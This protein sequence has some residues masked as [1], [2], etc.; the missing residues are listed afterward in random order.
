MATISLLLYIL[1]ANAIKNPA[2]D[3]RGAYSAAFTDVSGLRTGADVRTRGVQIG[4][5]TDVALSRTDDG[6]AV[7]NVTF[8]LVPPYRLTT[9][10]TLAI[11]YQ[12]LTG[13]RYIDLVTPAQ[14]GAPTNHLSTRMTTPSF[15]ITELFNGLQPVL[16]DFTT[17]ELNRF[18]QNALSV[19]EGDG[20]GLA[21]LLDSV[22]K[23]SDYTTDR[24]RVVSVLVDNLSRLADTLG[25]R[26]PE[27]I[28]FMRDVKL[29]IDA[30]MTVLDQF[31]QTAYYGPRFLEPV[32]RLLRELGLEPGLDIDKML[33]DAFSSSGLIAEAL[34]LLPNT[35]DTLQDPRLRTP[36]RGTMTC[37][38]GQARLPSKV[39]VLLNGSRVVICAPQ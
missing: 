14:P 35:L 5:V 20:S 9:T 19:V 18:M 25:G 4:K 21:P 36:V 27:L 26:S 11:K 13:I 39:D 3:A 33:A 23:L 15:D 2:P 37:P 8:S 34:R 12:N 16:K 1:I 31:G 10:T 22:Q 30:A 17:D 24:Q 6:A 38:R 7:A 28:E 29:P 32:D